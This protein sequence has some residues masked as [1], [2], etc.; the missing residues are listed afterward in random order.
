VYE[1]TVKGSETVLYSFTGKSDGG[2]PQAAL[3]ADAAGNL[4]GTTY[5][6]GVSH[7]GTVF[8]LVR[9]TSGGSWTLVVLHSFGGKDGANP[10]AGVSFDTAGNLYGTTSAGG[11]Q[12]YGTIFRLAPS[13]S[14]WNETVLHDFELQKDGGVPYAGIVVSSTGS[15]YGAATEG[16]G[17]GSNGGG[18][19]FEMS[20][21]GNGWS[22]NVLYN[23]H[24]WG[25]SGSFRN[26]MMSTGKIYATTHC[27]GAYSSGTIYELTLAGGT[28]SYKELYTFTGRS[29]GLFSFSSLTPDGKGFLWG[30]TKQGGGN[31]SGVIFKIKPK[32]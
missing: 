25:I 32:T 19:I 2:G 5:S 15:L 17:G 22:F 8:E 26:V 31:G 9:P 30:T 3:A 27:D 13:A 10:V 1:V 14:G 4:Y 11:A 12:T 16:G 23:L 24:G 29:D 7:K 18:T 6:G 21:S 28:W 20:P